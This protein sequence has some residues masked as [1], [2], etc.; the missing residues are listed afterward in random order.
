MENAEPKVSIIIPVYNGSDYLKEAIESAINQTYRN[1]EVI[2]VNDGSVDNGKTEAIALSFGKRIRYYSKFNGGVATALNMGI[3]KMT[4]EYFSWLSHDDVYYENKIEVQMQYLKGLVDKHTILYGGW[5]VIDTH[6]HITG[7]PRIEDRTDEKYL[8]IGIYPLVNG[9][10]NGCTL[11]IHKDCFAEAGGFDP[12]LRTTQD[13]TLWFKMFRRFPVY[14]HKDILL[15]SRIH[16]EQGSLKES[17]H[18]DEALVLWNRFVEE[19]T[20]HDIQG[21]YATLPVYYYKMAARLKKSYVPEVSRTAVSKL[22]STYKNKVSIILPVYNRCDC[23]AEAIESVLNQSYGHYE[24]IVVDDGSTDDTSRVLS[25]Y[26]DRISIIYQPNMGAAAARNAGI[27][28]AKGEYIAFIDSDDLWAPKHLAKHVETLDM[29]IECA[30]TY[31]VAQ[32]VTYKQEADAFVLDR[33][34]VAK[35][36]NGM[37]Y[38]SLLYI[39]NCVITTPSVV[40]RKLILDEIGCFNE[41]MRMCEDLDLWRRIAKKYQ[42]CSIPEVLTIVRI[43]ENQFDPEKYF[44][45]RKKYIEM[46]IADDPLITAETV[47]KLF[48][49]MY[50]TYY[51]DGC[52]GELI[53]GDMIENKALSPGTHQFVNNFINEIIRK[54]YDQFQATAL[55]N[56]QSVVAALEIEKAKLES[57]K[58][59]LRRRY[60]LFEDARL[61]TWGQFI[62]TMVKK[63]V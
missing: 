62:I 29:N 7:N 19:V 22:Q 3:E 31:N 63:I 38:P 28:A 33:C 34:E 15:K 52:N 10:I 30:M 12:N 54:K 4:G 20:E 58:A 16:P 1:I 39:E 46:A 47:R 45:E 13:Y 57:E 6:S 24:L 40:L 44:F 27:R 26:E 35:K 9:C 50:A 21:I 51:Q 18:R 8:N 49:E 55:E 14:F 25:Q 32:Y 23:V 42:V 56:A 11:L 43:R 2:V 60:A 17:G 37:I 48:L 41:S 59:T 53:I 5:D 36:M 61:T